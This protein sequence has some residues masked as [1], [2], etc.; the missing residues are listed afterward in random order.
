V[1]GLAAAAGPAMQ[2]DSWD[3]VNPADGFDVNLVAVADRQQLRRQRRERIGTW[4]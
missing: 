2:I 3:A 1:V 4:S